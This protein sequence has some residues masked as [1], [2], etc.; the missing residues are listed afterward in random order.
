MTW[1][2]NRNLLANLVHC[3]SV[4]L[5]LTRYPE[6]FSAVDVLQNWDTVPLP[7]R[8]DLLLLGVC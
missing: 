7:G 8:A 1:P 3:C 6:L 2:A 4:W 5:Q